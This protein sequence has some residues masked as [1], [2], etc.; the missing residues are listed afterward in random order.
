[1]RVKAIKDLSQLGE[2][3]FFATVAQ[4]LSIILN[5]ARSFNK[6]SEKLGRESSFHGA[7]VLRHIC[8]EELTKFAIL[9]DAVR[10]PCRPADR[11]TKQLDRFNSHL[12]KGL[13]NWAYHARPATL[14]QLQEYLDS[15]RVEYYLD[16]PNNVDWI[17]RNDIEHHREELLY[18]DYIEADEGHSWQDPCRYAHL[19]GAIGTAPHILEICEKLEA[20]GTSTTDGLRA[21]ADIWREISLHPNLSWHELRK[22]N[23][24]TLKE[25]EKRGVLTEQPEATYS[26]IVNEWQF[27]MYDLSLTKIP[28]D[29]ETLREQ[30]RNWWPDF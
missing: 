23:D 22:I 17:F 20:C 28:V 29:K 5:N 10:C 3:D 9:L 25:L 19:S 6:D 18:V 16:G 24:Q 8:E 11:F 4:G 7:R 27:P 14:G 13:Y 26:T 21:V 1:M 12:A 2:S 30:Q 15:K